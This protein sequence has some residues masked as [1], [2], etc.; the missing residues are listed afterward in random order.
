MKISTSRLEVIF[1]GNHNN[2]FKI[3]EQISKTIKKD[4]LIW[5]NYNLFE[6][7]QD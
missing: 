7:R 1:Q 4:P 5:G 6:T 2:R 3:L